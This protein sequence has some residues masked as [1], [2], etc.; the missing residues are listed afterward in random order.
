[1]YCMNCGVKLAETE[2]RCPLC[3]VEAFHPDILR[4][5]VEPLYPQH[6]YPTP[7]VNSRATQIIVTT[8]VLMAVLITL[9][10]DL[11]ISGSVT[12]SGFAMG[13]LGVG[14]VVFVLPY[15]FRKPNP[16]IFVPCGFVA[17]GLY[18][19]YIDLAT[20]G[21]WFLGFAFPVTACIGFIVT[22]VVTLL[23][24]LRS[25]RLYIF[26]GA[27]IVLGA[28]MLLMEFLLCTTFD[29]PRFIGWSAY[30]MIALVLLGAMLI[31]LAICRPAR[32]TM[33]RKFFL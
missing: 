14:Y 6:R 16:V 9:S 28:F 7:Q 11:Q 25:G 8:F 24:Y 21:S 33:E 18:L 12:W 19:L 31:F 1:M 5:E 10:I 2:K 13:A 4:E 23:R 17:V 26:G 20:G 3:G 32:E 30:P 27:S 15:W 22:T 29:R